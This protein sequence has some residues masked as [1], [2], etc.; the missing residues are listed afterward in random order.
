MRNNTRNKVNISCYVYVCIFN[1]LIT[2]K[3]KVHLLSDVLSY[4]R[5]TDKPASF[6]KLCIY[7]NCIALCWPL[8]LHT[9]R[10]LYVQLTIMH[11]WAIFLSSFSKNWLQ[12]VSGKYKMSPV[13]G[14]ITAGKLG[15]SK[16]GEREKQ[17]KR[18]VIV[19]IT[20]VIRRAHL[21]SCHSC[22][23]QCGLP[24]TSH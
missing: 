5:H 12:T 9:C 3:K 23:T 14:N 7:C 8:V 13:T 2:L 18:S 21:H 10:Q 20:M 11:L 24:A 17:M 1:H 22:V 6:P 15:R 16:G 4:K 19:Y